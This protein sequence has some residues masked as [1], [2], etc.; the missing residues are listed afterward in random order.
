[1]RKVFVFGP[2]Y[3]RFQLW[4]SFVFLESLNFDVKLTENG[5]HINLHSYFQKPIQKFDICFIVI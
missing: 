4:V 5:I 3:I 2:D 1:M